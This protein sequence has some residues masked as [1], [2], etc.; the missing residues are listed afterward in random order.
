MA[1]G[2]VNPHP[3]FNPSNKQ[4]AG[5]VEHKVVEGDE[6]GTL[7][8]IY[9][10]RISDII[11][12][13]PRHIGRTSA[14]NYYLKKHTFVRVPTNNVDLIIAQQG[15]DIP[16]SINPSRLNQLLGQP[17][18]PIADAPPAPVHGAAKIGIMPLDL[19]NKTGRQSTPQEIAAVV[20]EALLSGDRDTTI[21]SVI[22]EF[23]TQPQVLAA[24]SARLAQLGNTNLAANGIA[25]GFDWVL[26]RT[27]QTKYKGVAQLTEN[28]LK[29]GPERVADVLASAGGA[30][31]DIQAV[32]TE[33][34]DILARSGNDPAVQAVY[35]Q[36]IREVSPTYGGEVAFGMPVDGPFDDLAAKA[37]APAGPTTGAEEAAVRSTSSAASARGTADVT[38]FNLDADGM[39]GENVS[40]HDRQARSQLTAMFASSQYL[41]QNIKRLYTGDGAALPGMSGIR[42]T[43]GEGRVQVSSGR[44][45]LDRQMASYIEREMTSRGISAPIKGEF[46]RSIFIA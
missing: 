40:D 20:G 4:F 12:L 45:D 46:T 37:Q 39:G 2:P 33:L 31:T 26:A 6:L 13:N 1:V 34:R 42:I 7:A 24:I 17:T 23:R 22:S 25:Q 8:R 9:G 41:D 43:I 30:T 16:G 10:C 14:G 11:A 29:V 21:D 32:G 19:G 5:A 18:L 27:P 3:G 15:R 38:L 35:D 36:F 28:M 44:P